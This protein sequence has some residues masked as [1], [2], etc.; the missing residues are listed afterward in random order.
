[1]PFD[2]I[3]LLLDPFEPPAAGVAYEAEREDGPPDDCR[4]RSRRPVAAYSL[5]R[6]VYRACG[7]RIRSPVRH[8]GIV[9]GVAPPPCWPWRPDF[10][11]PAAV[12]AA[13]RGRASVTLRQH[14]FDHA[15]CRSA[16]GRPS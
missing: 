13:A 11:S 6:P 14:S 9:V 5:R 16:P 8:L 1:D 3:H 4:E 10:P 12:S 15:C 2:R 7:G